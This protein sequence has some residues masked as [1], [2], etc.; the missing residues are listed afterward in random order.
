[1]E[2]NF[3]LALTKDE[4]ARLDMVANYGAAMGNRSCANVAKNDLERWAQNLG[5]RESEWLMENAGKC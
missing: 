1:M 2:Q 3:P 4:I 5:S